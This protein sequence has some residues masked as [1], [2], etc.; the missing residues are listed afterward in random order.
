VWLVALVPRRRPDL[1]LPSI[2]QALG[3]RQWRVGAGDGHSRLV[4]ARSPAGSEVVR[5]LKFA[6]AA[7]TSA[8]RGGSTRRQSA[9][10]QQ[11]QSAALEWL[12][13]Q[14]MARNVELIP[15]QPSDIRS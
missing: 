6:D 15:D 5:V 4:E 3:I 14:H 8:H 7:A 10:Q 12:R 9:L 13:C 2:A 1:V 11:R